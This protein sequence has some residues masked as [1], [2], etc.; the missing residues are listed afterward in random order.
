M[1]LWVELYY[2]FIIGNIKCIDFFYNMKLHSYR[3]SYFL[4]MCMTDVPFFS[5]IS[6]TCFFLSSSV[7]SAM[8][9]AEALIDDE[10]K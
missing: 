8:E 9:C 7:H 5:N 4:K 2:A 6:E 3:Y 10:L 1:Q